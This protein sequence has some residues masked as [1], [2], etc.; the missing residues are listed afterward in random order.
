MKA[1]VVIWTFYIALARLPSILA[2]GTCSN[3]NIYC[4][5][6]SDGT[7]AY[8]VRRD[9]WESVGQLY[10]RSYINSLSCPLS[11]E[12]KAILQSRQ[13][14]DLIDGVCA[15]TKENLIRN[16]FT[17]TS[18]G[19]VTVLCDS[20]KMIKTMGSGLAA[21]DV[22]ATALTDPPT[23]C[24]CLLQ[25]AASW[26]LGLI[27]ADEFSFQCDSSEEA[28]TGLD[29]TTGVCLNSQS[30]PCIRGSE[31][32]IEIS[33]QSSANADLFI[34]MPPDSSQSFIYCHNISGNT[35]SCKSGTDSL[36]GGSWEIKMVAD[37]NDNTTGTEY[38]TI[39]INDGPPTED[40][41]DLIVLTDTA[42]FN[43][44]V[45][46]K[47]FF[48]GMEVVSVVPDLSKA[49]PTHNAWKG[50]IDVLKLSFT[51]DD[52]FGTYVRSDLEARP[53]SP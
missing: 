52:S 12:S 2:Q 23:S 6:P 45:T 14:E 30:T 41:F 4:V 16:L 22:L 50:R 28:A 24:E 34:G 36:S 26:S 43:V 17:T 9:L 29:V 53:S 46:V 15:S 37:P 27:Q 44:D 21:F 19:K 47:Y 10:D 13:S 11:I 18:V 20:E 32:R 25:A 51:A 1:F 39:T 31:W 49:G 35:E 5:N 42:P 40:R 38:A 33:W 7:T 3:V 48:D 8:C